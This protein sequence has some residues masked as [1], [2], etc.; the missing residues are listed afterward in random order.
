MLQV[1][2]DIFFL[3]FRLATYTFNSSPKKNNIR[4]YCVEMWTTSFRGKLRYTALHNNVRILLDLPTHAM[5]AYPLRSLCTVSGFSFPF[6]SHSIAASDLFRIR[7]QL[8][9]WFWWCGSL[10][11]LS[12]S[13]WLETTR[14]FLCNNGKYSLSMNFSAK[15]APFI[16]NWYCRTS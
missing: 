8:W 7:C 3:F 12:T 1:A 6:L 2:S 5:K 14:T 13:N 4:Y 9:G 16:C 10:L 11:L 15:F